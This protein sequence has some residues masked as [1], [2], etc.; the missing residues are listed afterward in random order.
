[1]TKRR[2]SAG[3]STRAVHGGEREHRE[4]DA[5]S[6]PIHQTSTF[7]FPDSEQ[8]RAYQEGRLQRHEYGRYG[9][10]TWSAVERKLCDLEGAEAAVLFGVVAAIHVWA[11]RPF[12]RISESG[13]RGPKGMHRL[14]AT[15]HLDPGA[16]GQP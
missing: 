11:R 14:G 6:T 3:D 9:N 1:M 15:A 5:V 8:L 10:P 7:W 12:L 4:S 2:G 13:D 16:V